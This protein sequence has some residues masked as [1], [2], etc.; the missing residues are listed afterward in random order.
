[1]EKEDA[2]VDAL[3]KKENAVAAALVKKKNAAAVRSEG[4]ACFKPTPLPNSIHHEVE[5]VIALPED[6]DTAAVW[7]ERKEKAAAIHEVVAET[8]ATPR[9]IIKAGVCLGL[10]DDSAAVIGSKIQHF[11][12]A[13]MG[14]DKTVVARVERLDAATEPVAT[15]ATKIVETSDVTATISWRKNV[16]AIAEQSQNTR[17]GIDRIMAS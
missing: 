8:V 16:V 4:V 10:V 15:S 1:M 6:K 14:K 7:M 5:F 11:D 2:T 17:T 12:A 3:M 13:A 9:P